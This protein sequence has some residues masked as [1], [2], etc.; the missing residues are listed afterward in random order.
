MAHQ[1]LKILYIAG[2]ARSG[3][4]ILQNLLGEIEGFFAAGELQYLWK[5]AMTESSRCGCGSPIQECVVWGEVINRVLRNSSAAEIDIP[6]LFRW[7]QETVRLR[8][9]WRL[10][11]RRGGTSNWPLLEAYASTMAALY[12]TTADV[13]GAR[14][15]VDSSKKYSGAAFLRLLPGVDPH[16]VHLVRDPRAVVYSWNR[17]KVNVDDAGRRESLPRHGPLFSSLQWMQVNLMTEVVCRRHGSGRSILVRYED[18]AAQPRATVRK[19]VDLVNEFPETLPFL[20]ER[21]AE[22]GTNHT[23]W[24]NV[25]RF[26]KGTVT[27]RE[28][29][30]WLQKLSHRSR[31]VTTAVTLPMLHRYGYRIRDHTRRSAPGTRKRQSVE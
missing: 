8:H 19:I 4:T 10:L 2:P 11:R 20:D 5:R 23:V 29:K 15:I 18:F 30:E 16:I 27:V 12:R 3:S 14:V 17:Q 26:E 22:L 7:H 24:G 31:A 1:N 28:D 9:T 21:T 6:T 25:S 13:T